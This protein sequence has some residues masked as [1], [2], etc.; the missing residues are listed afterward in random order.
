[1]RHTPGPWMF[2]LGRGANP[3]FHVQTTSGYQI[4]STTELNS[5]PQAKDENEQRQAN[6]RL[7]AASPDL[8]EACELVQKWMLGGQPAPFSDSKV[9]EAVGEAISK[10]KDA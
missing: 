1:M 3:R 10:A 9:L 5:H 6:A 2:H 4:A 8:L 7:I